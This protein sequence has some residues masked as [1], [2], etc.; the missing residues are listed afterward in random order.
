MTYTMPDSAAMPPD[1]AAIQAPSSSS[2]A[3]APHPARARKR[4]KAYGN[5]F[6]ILVPALLIGAWFVSDLVRPDKFSVFPSL[7]NVVTCWADW[8]FDTTQGRYFY[9]GTWIVDFTA[10]MIRIIG[11]LVIGSAAAV[12]FGLSVLWLPIIEKITDPII[13]I[14]R[15][16]PKTAFLPFAILLFG[17]G[18]GPAMF[19]TIYGVFLIVY[20]Q[21]IMSI[22]LV[23]A[24]LKH[25]AAMLGASKSQVLRTVVLPAALPGIC[26][27]IRIGAS[28]AWLVLILAEMLAV[29][30]GFGYVL[31]HAYEFMRMDLVVAAM[32][33]IGL[34]GFVT[35]KVIVALMRKHLTWAEDI[36]Q[37]NV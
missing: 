21:V 14:L 10:S 33:T 26:G 13:Q 12:L 36:A 37:A 6:S 8:I 19:M 29:R 20:V 22:K 25:A 15:P 1:A 5:L 31:W 9:S 30:E 23:P 34:C 7:Q 17:L 4:S 2:R 24:D 35:D 27:G 28:Y 3:A 32:L 18:N 16:I 11:G